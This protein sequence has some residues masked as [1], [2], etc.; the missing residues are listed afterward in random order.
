MEDEQADPSSADNNFDF[1]NAT[2]IPW[3][4]KILKLDLLL[5]RIVQTVGAHLPHE[6]KD[7][8]TLWRK[9]NDMFF[10]QPVIVEYKLEKLKIELDGKT[11]CYRRLIDHSKL[12]CTCP[13]DD[14]YRIR[15]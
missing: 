4:N 10:K 11:K 13:D 2:E 12:L 8:D 14:N 7:K 15:D 5:L 3:S 6:T 9:V 1:T